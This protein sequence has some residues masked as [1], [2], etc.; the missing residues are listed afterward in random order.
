MKKKFSVEEIQK[1]QENPYVK[2]VSESTITYTQEFR[3]YFILEYE[4]GKAP[5][6][7][8]TNAGFNRSILGAERCKSLSNNFRKMA[9]RED[10]LV[11]TRKTNSGRPLTR[12][13]SQD[14]KIQRLEQK[15][16]YL[17]QENSFLKKIKFLDEKTRH[18]HDQK[19][20]SKS[21][22]K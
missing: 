21:S 20:S 18:S 9:K 4:K 13:L 6:E 22:M 5:S 10:G 17:E 3:E 8:L 16:K 19:R 12:D 14:E 7:I 11:D 1:L 15:V 2:R